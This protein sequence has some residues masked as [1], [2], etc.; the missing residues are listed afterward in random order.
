MIHLKEGKTERCE[1]LPNDSEKY[2]LKLKLT[3][4]TGGDLGFCTIRNDPR[5]CYSF[6]EEVEIAR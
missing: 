4:E 1:I 6:Y 5:V 2:D 3:G